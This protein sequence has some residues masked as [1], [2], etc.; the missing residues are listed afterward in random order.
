MFSNTETRQERQARINEQKK[1]DAEYLKECLTR[2]SKQVGLLSPELWYASDDTMLSVAN[3]LEGE[4]LFTA[5]D[6][7]RFFEKPY[8]FESDMQELINTIEE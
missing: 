6:A 4:C 1:Q 8:H 7:I 3:I 2:T 5:S